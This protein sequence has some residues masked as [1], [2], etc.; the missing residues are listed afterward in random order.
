MLVA[1]A[2]TSFSS[3]YQRRILPSN[4]SIFSAELRTSSISTCN[5][6]HFT[7]FSTE[8]YHMHQIVI[9]KTSVLLRRDISS[10]HRKCDQRYRIDSNQ[11]PIP[12]NEQPDL[13]AKEAA[14]WPPTPEPPTTVSDLKTI[15]KFVSHKT[16]ENNKLRHIKPMLSLWRPP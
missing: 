5:L 7:Q 9:S 10:T 1:C 8:W 11:S 4:F 16:P 13:A 2:V 12:G 14:K 3:I 15:R 6:T